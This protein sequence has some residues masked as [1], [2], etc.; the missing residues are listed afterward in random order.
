MDRVS[1]GASEAIS[2]G[3]GVCRWAVTPVKLHGGV[4]GQTTAM[5]VLVRRVWMGWESPIEGLEALP[6]QPGGAELVLLLASRP[7]MV[8]RSPQWPPLVWRDAGF[9]PTRTLDFSLS[10]AGSGAHGALGHWWVVSPD[11][12]HLP[13]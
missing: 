8:G 12:G 5:P 11:S 13:S 3:S 6:V 2:N 7:W 4:I 1:W 10:M 9:F